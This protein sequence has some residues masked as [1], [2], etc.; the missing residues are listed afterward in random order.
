MLVP[1]SPTRRCEAL[2]YGLEVHPRIGSALVSHRPTH[3]GMRI[4][5][6]PSSSSGWTRTNLGY[7]HEFAFPLG[8]RGTVLSNSLTLTA[9]TQA[10]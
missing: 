4:G 3:V 5:Y 9:S 10:V 8:H 2:G 7:V 1:L 6:L